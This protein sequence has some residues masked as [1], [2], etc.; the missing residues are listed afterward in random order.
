MF[1]SCIEESSKAGLQGNIEKTE[2]MSHRTEINE[3][4]MKG[5][6]EEIETRKDYKYLGRIMSFT[7]RMNKELRGR[8]EAAWKSFW[9][10]KHIYKN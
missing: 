9:A 8:K 6:G 4:E 7:D 5:G 2:A 10:L 1:Q 3:R